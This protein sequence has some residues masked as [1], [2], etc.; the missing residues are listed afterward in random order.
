MAKVYFTLT[1]LCY[2]Y[3]SD[4]LK[5]GMKLYLEKEPDND[6]DK[7]AIRVTRPGMGTIGYVANSIRTVQG[8]TMSAGRLYDKI[9]N[10]AKAKVVAV[11]PRGAICKVCK[12]S[13]LTNKQQTLDE[14]N[15]GSLPAW[16]AALESDLKAA[17]DII[18]FAAGAEND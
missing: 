12:K 6:Y 16:Q 3:G 1:G 4:F 8:D 11:T 5:E 17:E 13:L 2:R 7:E 15:K 18:L 9:G 14:A 10:T